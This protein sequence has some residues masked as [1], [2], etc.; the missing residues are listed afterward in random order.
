VRRGIEESFIALARYHGLNPI[1]ATADKTPE[2]I[3]LGT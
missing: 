2:W 1:T 3:A